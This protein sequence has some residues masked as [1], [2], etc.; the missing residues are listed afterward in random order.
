MYSVG[1]LVTSNRAGLV[2]TIRNSAS[3]DSIKK[4]GHKNKLSNDGI[5]YTLYDYF[6]KVKH[7]RV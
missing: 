2:E 3:V 5:S 1:I 6:V 7:A 4:Q